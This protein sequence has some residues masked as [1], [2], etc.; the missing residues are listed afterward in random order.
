MTSGSGAPKTAIDDVKTSFGLYSGADRIASS[1]RWVP[2]TF[3]RY[4]FSKS[5]SASPDTTAAR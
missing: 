1:R 3:T 2:W 4:P 5:V